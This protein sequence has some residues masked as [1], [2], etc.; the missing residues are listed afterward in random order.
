[1]MLLGTRSRLVL[2]GVVARALKPASS[3]STMAVFNFLE[4]FFPTI[5][6]HYNLLTTENPVEFLTI[7]H[8]NNVPKQKDIN[9]VLLVLPGAQKLRVAQC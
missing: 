1:M 5:A 9:Q 7:T 4:A 6:K 3:A 2:I 8:R